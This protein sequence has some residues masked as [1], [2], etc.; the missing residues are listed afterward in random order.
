MSKY[1]IQS[2]DHRNSIVFRMEQKIERIPFSGCWIWTG[3]ADRN[4][5]GVV[6]YN[7]NHC[8]THRLYF[9]LYR[10]EVPQGKE[11]NHLCRVRSCVNPDHLE[12]VTHTENMRYS[13]KTHIAFCKRGHRRS[14]DNITIRGGMRHCKE[15]D[16]MR[17]RIFQQKLREKRNGL[18]K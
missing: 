7:R 5:Y 4:G 17:S 8:L 12:A 1:Q 10:G 9:T 11:I 18:C 6:G 3:C 14:G 13:P 15:C 2:Q 16:R